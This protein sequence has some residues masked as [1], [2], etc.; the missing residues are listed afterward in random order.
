MHFTD[1][2]IL[3]LAIGLKI[4]LLAFIFQDKILTALAKI[5]AVQK[6]TVSE[7]F[8]VSVVDKEEQQNQETDIQDLELDSVE[9]TKIDCT[10]ESTEADFS[11]DDSSI[12][13]T[14]G[15][16]KLFVA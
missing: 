2:F 5:K 15:N 6:S 7:S 11:E 1:S 9:Q 8:D 3:V 4:A 14:E 12:I 16:E 13:E 10:E